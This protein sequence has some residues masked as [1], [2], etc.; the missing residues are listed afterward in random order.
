[1]NKTYQVSTF[2]RLRTAILI[3]TLF[4]ISLYSARKAWG[5]WQAQT[6]KTSDVIFLNLD[7][8]TVFPALLLSLVAISCLPITWN[9]VIELLTQI[10][11]NDAGLLLKT[12]VYRIF[13]RWDEI[14]S[15]DVISG[16][17]EDSTVALQVE[18]QTSRAD[19]PALL[20]GEGGEPDAIAS[21]LSE[22]DLREDK[23]LRQRIKAEK[24][25]RNENLR[26]R[27]A[28]S[29][30][31][32]IKSWWSYLYPQVQ[33]P[34]RLL[35]YPSIEK[36]SVLLTEIERYLAGA[37]KTEKGISQNPQPDI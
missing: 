27:V 36:R 14:K 34:D 3:L 13:Y 28:R 15:L 24:K 29:D 5:L 33:R 12:P 8:N 20:Y 26:Q 16:P 30:G 6:A 21:Y 10:T 11:L 31:T 23:E 18:T 32:G 19:D 22:A 2:G 25:L 7:V 9:L 37:V 35:L 1:M 17:A 4:L